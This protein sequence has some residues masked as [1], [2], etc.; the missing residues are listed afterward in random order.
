M[1]RKAKQ[2][3]KK[4]KP[5]K[6]RSTNILDAQGN[7][8]KDKD[9][10]K[11]RWKEYF[12]ELYDAAG[13][14]NECMLESKAEVDPEDLGPTILHTETDSSMKKLKKGK[15]PGLDDIPGEL[16]KDLGPNARGAINKLDNLIYT[17]GE[18]PAHFIVS[19]VVK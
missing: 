12:E 16:M 14:P 9:K 17:S 4:Y 10:I 3:G 18:W 15:A 8:L 13:K 2:I 7:I 19:R 11:E 6:G 5:T 1:Y